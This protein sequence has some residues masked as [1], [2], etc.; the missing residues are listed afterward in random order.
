MPSI[1]S[2]A[3]KIISSNSHM[4]RNKFQDLSSFASTFKDGTKQKVSQGFQTVANSFSAMKCQAR[5]KLQP[6]SPIMPYLALASA[7]AAAAYFGLRSPTASSQFVPKSSDN[8][9]Q[10]PNS[11]LAV[12]DS[13]EVLKDHLQSLPSFQN[14]SYVGETCPLL[15]EA[16][17]ILD[18]NHS[19]PMKTCIGSEECKFTGFGKII[20]KNG[21]VYEGE[22]KDGRPTRKGK[23]TWSNGDVYEGDF[24]DTQRTGNGKLI[25]SNGNV[26]EGEFKDDRLIGKGKFAWTGGNVYEGDFKD[27]VKEGKGKFTWI[28][29]DVYEGN[30]K[31]DWRTKGNLTRT[32]GCW[33][34]GL[35]SHEKSIDGK[36]IEKIQVN[37][38]S[39]LWCA[40]KRFVNF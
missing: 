29:G 39:S 34:E 2:Y 26:Y 32:D 12:S 30:F 38:D 4:E 35:W 37:T 1:I 28:D 3:P 8:L 27:D 33:Y 24:K 25:W 10:N 14:T 23:V 18:N 19:Q 6:L 36:V 17:N 20:F 21:D 40:F 22:L 16:I 31:D 11:T 15:P 9:Q 13:I 5:K 7:L